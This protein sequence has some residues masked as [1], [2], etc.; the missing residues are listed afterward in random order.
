[1]STVLEILN[2]TNLGA[3]FREI[4]TI[5]QKNVLIYVLLFGTIECLCQISNSNS[6]KNFTAQKQYLQGKYDFAYEVKKDARFK[7]TYW[8]Y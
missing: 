3:S 4:F 1:M 6:K 8:G 5:M 7:I 2:D